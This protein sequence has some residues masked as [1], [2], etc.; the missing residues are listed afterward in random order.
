L[1]EILVDVVVDVGLEDREAE[2]LSH[3]ALGV[4]DERDLFKGERHLTA[5]R[6]RGDKAS[7]TTT[8]PVFS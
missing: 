7:V 5:S 8:A 1:E 2:K 4:S 6:L 3:V